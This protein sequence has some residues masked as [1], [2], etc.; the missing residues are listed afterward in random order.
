[1]VACAVLVLGA[2]CTS[3]EVA[4]HRAAQQGDES[5][6]KKL[7]AEQPALA[8][9]KE[10]TKGRTPLFVAR[11]RA[12]AELLVN[13]GARLD[14]PDRSNK[15][16]IHAAMSGEVIDFLVEKG[17][18]P[19]TPWG[20]MGATALHAAESELACEALVRHGLDV[21][22]RDKYGKTPLHQHVGSESDLGVVHWLLKNGADAAAADNEGRTP[23]HGAHAKVIPVLLSAG[24]YV[25]AQE[26]HGATP[27][28]LAVLHDD[29]PRAE[30]LLAG[31]AGTGWRL[32]R[33]TVV[34]TF[35][36]GGMGQS[37]ASELT[38]L[39][40]AGSD[41]MKALLRKHGATE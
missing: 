25:D 18:S 15:Q 23:L 7:L 36:K 1:M 11:T 31:G 41:K 29:V 37:G 35:G 14:E 9:H 20:Q 22:A 16:P 5:K 6:V 17:V 40:L 30:A 33:N 13:A 39:Q 32:N 8:R 27:L 10:S 2:A 12:I 4:I 21:N 26:K 38:P 28:H 24:V 19:F 3:P 34:V